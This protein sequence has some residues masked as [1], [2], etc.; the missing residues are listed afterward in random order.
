MNFNKVIQV[1]IIWSQFVFSF[2]TD[3]PVIATPDQPSITDDGIEYMV[4]FNDTCI[5]NTIMGMVNF[6]CVVVSGR[7]PLTISWQVGDENF[8]SDGRSMV[9]TINDT[10]SKLVIGVDTGASLDLDLNEYRCTA[11][12]S[13]GTDTAVSTLSRCGKFGSRNSYCKILLR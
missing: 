4:G 5:N 10:V 12:N 6:T 9:V 3:P 2:L 8:T 1:I 11:I 13:D 7:R